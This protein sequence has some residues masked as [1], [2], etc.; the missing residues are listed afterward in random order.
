MF[1][2]RQNMAKSGKKELRLE[3]NTK[4][5]EEKKKTE[6]ILSFFTL[7][8]YCDVM[9]A[10]F[11]LSYFFLSFGGKLIVEGV[12]IAGVGGK[13][14]LRQNH[15]TSYPQ[16]VLTKVT[17]SSGGSLAEW[18]GCWTCNLVVLSSSPPPC[19]S[20]ELFLVAPSSTPWLCSV[21]S[22]LVCLLPVGIFE[23]LMFIS[24][25]VFSHCI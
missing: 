6:E 17:K 3:Q 10:F 21:N 9:L 22:Q 25:C 16:E 24:V 15:L 23:H 18:L 8:W 20:L 11:F 2:L 13:P 1:L 7:M 19:H 4:E 5:T 12:N 14:K